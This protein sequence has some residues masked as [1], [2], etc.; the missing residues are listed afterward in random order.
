VLR[1][2]YPVWHLASG[3]D[4]AKLKKAGRPVR[5]APDVLL[6]LMGT[7]GMLKKEL[8]DAAMEKGWGKTRAYDS[9][10]QLISE[11]KIREAGSLIYKND[12]AAP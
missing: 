5:H 2:Q 3:I 4:P 10:K 12:P 6:S 11:S 9:I 1:W 8:A 7:S